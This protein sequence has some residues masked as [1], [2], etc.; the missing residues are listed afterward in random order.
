MWKL[1]KFEQVQSKIGANQPQK[2][3]TGR[4]DHAHRAHQKVEE[5]FQQDTLEREMTG[6]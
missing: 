4:V 2:P 6:G 5:H 1:K 3:P